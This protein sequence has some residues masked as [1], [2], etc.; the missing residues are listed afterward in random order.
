MSNCVLPRSPSSPRFR[1]AHILPTWGFC[2]DLNPIANKVRKW[3]SS[4]PPKIVRTKESAQTCPAVAASG[5]FL[6]S[7]G[8]ERPNTQIKTI[9]AKPLRSDPHVLPHS[10]RCHV[11]FLPR[12]LVIRALADVRRRDAFFSKT[13][14]VECSQHLPAVERFLGGAE[15]CSRAGTGAQQHVGGSLHV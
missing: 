3:E 8:A 10:E 13:R 14:P 1:K 9:W 2:V 7:S 15:K 11:L 6:A 4:D 5:S 12:L